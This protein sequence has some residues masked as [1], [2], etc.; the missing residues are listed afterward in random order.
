MTNARFK[1]LCEEIE[2]LMDS[3]HMTDFLL[4]CSH[5]LDEKA[6]HV[7][8]NWQDHTS[9]KWI[10]AAADAVGSAAEYVK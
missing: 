1:A 7:A 4:A 3:H 9:A 10:R 5:V 8:T 6:E 2:N